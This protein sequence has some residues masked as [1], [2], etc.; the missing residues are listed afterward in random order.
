VRSVA[1]KFWKCKISHTNSDMVW[2]F[3]M[4]LSICKPVSLARRIDSYS[5]MMFGITRHYH[6]RGRAVLVPNCSNQSNPSRLSMMLMKSSSKWFF[7]VDPSYHSFVLVC[8]RNPQVPKTAKSICWNTKRVVI[9]E[10]FLNILL[11]FSCSVSLI[12]WWLQHEKVTRP[13]FLLLYHYL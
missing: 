9:H 6:V 2:Q 3:G 4:K 12:G 10:Y 8:T 1:Q 7:E 13:W 11:H 5:E